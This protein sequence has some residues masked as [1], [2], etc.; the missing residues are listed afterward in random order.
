MQS[1]GILK[2]LAFLRFSFVISKIFRFFF[3]FFSPFEILRF[4][5]IFP[6]IF[7]RFSLDFHLEIS[8]IYLF[9]FMILEFSRF[10]QNSFQEVYEILWSELPLDCS[11][12]TISKIPLFNGLCTNIGWRGRGVIRNGFLGL[13]G[14]SAGQ[15]CSKKC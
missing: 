5:E 8:A 3:F 2:C 10:F 15:P 14:F 7:A 4:P 11:R 9:L 6:E 13:P 1:R 12:G